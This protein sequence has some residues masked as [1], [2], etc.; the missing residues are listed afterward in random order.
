MRPYI[1]RSVRFR[2]NV[3][4][5]RSKGVKCKVFP[6]LASAPRHEDVSGVEV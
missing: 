4:L 6:E 1:C 5:L 3:T 2:R